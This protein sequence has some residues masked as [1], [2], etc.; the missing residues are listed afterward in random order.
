MT[1]IE[2]RPIGTFTS[3]HFSTQKS[4]RRAHRDGAAMTGTVTLF[5]P[6]RNF[7]FVGL[8]DGKI[9]CWETDRNM[10][11]KRGKETTARVFH[12][13]KGGV[14]CMVFVESLC[15]GVMLSG[16]ADRCIKMWDLSDQRSAHITCVGSFYGHGGTVLSIEY[17]SEMMVSSS[18]DGFL[19]IWR[20]QSVAKLLRFPPYTIRQ[21]ISPNPKADSHAAARASRETWFLSI[22][23][24]GGEVPSI[25]AGDSEGHVHVYKPDVVQDGDHDCFLL[26]W[27]VKIHEF[28]VARI[29][30]V[31]ME[32]FLFTLSYD[33]KFKTLDSLSGQI[34]FEQANQ[35]GVIFTGLSWDLVH[36]DVVVADEKGNIG[37]YNLYMESCVAWRSLTNDPIIQIHY[38]AKTHRLLLLC[39]HALRVV[40]VVR[41][42]K[43][44]ELKE[45]TEP[46]VSIASRTTVQ[47]SLLYTAAMDNTIRMWD[48]DSLECV[49]CLREK[50][51]EITA[52]VYLPRANVIITG[53]ENS[54]LKMWA[55]DNQQEAS[56]K[57]VSGQSVHDNTI[58]CLAFATF[59]SGEAGDDLSQKLLAG[60]DSSDMGFESL[61]AGSYDRQISFWKVTLSVDGTAMAKFERA[62]SAHEDV[63]DEVQAVIYSSAAR[64]VFTGGNAGVVRQWRLGWSRDLV[65][66]YEGHEDAITCFDVEGHFLFSGSVDCTIRIWETTQAYP[67]KVVQV[68]GVTV[69]ALLVLPESGF[70]ASCASDG[71]VVFWDPQVGQADVRVLQTYE[72]PEEFRAL[73]YLEATGT[74]LVG[75]ESGKIVAFPLPKEVSTGPVISTL[76][77]VLSGI[78]TPPSDQEGEAN[79]TLDKLEALRKKVSEAD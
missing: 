53:H 5:V 30:S 2:F 8:S 50:K 20:D 37:F 55:F 9:L 36:Q 65:A 10:M 40:D 64:A 17:G 45:H 51:H 11:E 1:S 78:E 44:S 32:P 71:K 7:L 26:A 73:S 21:R 28:G 54:E 3:P 72:Q 39:P 33:Q 74:V 59:A 12:E 60:S 75:C 35:C 46:I 16:A 25:F 58:S 18:T 49:K 22:A 62:F 70:V 52:M 67:L 41:G 13:H 43:F 42:V 48:T 27:K 56:L 77:E 76:P 61:I 69:Q 4:S 79:A 6:E 23:I 57:T 14:K 66:E 24:R 47:G 68:H 63:H 34:I 15:E 19:F 29:M 38:E 31:P